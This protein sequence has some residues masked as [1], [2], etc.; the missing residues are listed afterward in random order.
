MTLNLGTFLSDVGDVLKELLIDEGTIKSIIA[1]LESE[2]LP[3]EEKFSPL[4]DGV[5]S[6]LPAGTMMTFHTNNAQ[7]Y[8]LDVM[9]EMMEILGLYRDGVRAYQSG[10]TTTD[11]FSGAELSKIGHAVERA[12]RVNAAKLP[13]AES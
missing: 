10:S 12:D 1:S 13:G 6:A 5:F 8:L 9:T 4:P 7:A 3:D 2:T 11:E